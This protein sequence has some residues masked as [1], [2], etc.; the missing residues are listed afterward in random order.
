MITAVIRKHLNSWKL[1]T[2]CLPDIDTILI[3][4]GLN[5]RLERQKICNFAGWIFPSV[6][7]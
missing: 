1:L 5:I 6:R 2:Q 7:N 4:D 3:A